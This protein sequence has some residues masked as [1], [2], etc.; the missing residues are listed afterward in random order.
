MT[1]L[2][3]WYLLRDVELIANRTAA[4]RLALGLPY[5]KAMNVLI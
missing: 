4:N 5:A 1:T 2:P 3:G